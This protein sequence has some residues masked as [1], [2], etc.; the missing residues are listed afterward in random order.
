LLYFSNFDDHKEST[1]IFI[2][3]GPFNSTC[4]P[5]QAGCG[6]CA[7]RHKDP[8]KTNTLVLCKAPDSD[9]SS[10]FFFSSFFSSFFTAI[11][12]RFFLFFLFQG[13]QDP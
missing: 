4:G 5:E 9:S 2:S 7:L 1:K 11:N 12:F 6:P 3:V 10:T 13:I 8:H